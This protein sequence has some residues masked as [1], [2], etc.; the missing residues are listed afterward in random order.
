M[1]TID[2]TEMKAGQKGKV[3]EI[4]G[5]RGMMIKLEALGIRPGVVITKV[6]A[7]IMHGPVIVETGGTRVAIGFGMARRIILKPADNES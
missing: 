1:N 6:S 2:L 4:N 7:Q 3:N 5:G